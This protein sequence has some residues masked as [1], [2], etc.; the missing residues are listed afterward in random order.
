MEDFC[1]CIVLCSCP[2]K[3][4]LNEQ[5]VKVQGLRLISSAR[6]VLSLVFVELSVNFTHSSSSGKAVVLLAVFCNCHC[7]RQRLDF[8]SHHISIY[9]TL[10]C[11]KALG[12]H[13]SGGWG[14]EPVS[15]VIFLSWNKVNLASRL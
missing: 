5:H 13:S 4:V 1:K 6:T 15:P 12:S 11:K 8:S 3:M 10:P 14:G 7:E 9:H 2:C